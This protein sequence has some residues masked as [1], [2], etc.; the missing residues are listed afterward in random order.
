MKP[1]DPE[2]PAEKRKYDDPAVLR[3]LKYQ[4]IN[5]DTLREC[6]VLV[7][8]IPSVRYSSDEIDAVQRFVERGGGLLLVSDHTNYERSGTI[9]N[10]I[11]RPMGFITRPDLLYGLGPSA[12]DELY[13]APPVP[14]PVVQ[15][16][17][18]LDFAVSNSVEPGW[19]WGRPVGPGQRA[20]S[21][22]G[23]EYHHDNF[24]PFA[25]HAPDMRYGPFVQVWAAQLRPGPR[26]RLH[27]LD[28]SVE[29]RPLPTG[30]G[31][32]G[33]R[34]VAVAEPHGRRSGA[35][36][37]V[38]RLRAAGSRTV[39]GPHAPRRVVDVAGRR[40]VRLG[41]GV[42]RRSGGATKRHAAVGNAG[43]R[44]APWCRSSSTAR[45]PTWP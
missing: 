44:P 18:P 6:D 9:M 17:G 30:Q 19:S 35:V 13:V 1:D 20:C 29:L 7:I 15:R 16:M 37:A 22:M 43:R 23:P 36:A 45:F 5:D 27:R 28:D 26:D 33:R 12:D 40:H 32:T 11:T 2:R 4:E 10:D 14:H 3:D 31:P 34:H 8:Q 21:S 24:M 42:G 38:L 41:R 39:A 25:Q